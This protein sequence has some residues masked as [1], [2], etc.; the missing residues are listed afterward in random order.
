MMNLNDLVLINCRIREDYWPSIHKDICKHLQLKYEPISKNSPDALASGE[1]ETEERIKL[2]DK[3][4]GEC[5]AKGAKC[6]ELT[7]L[8]LAIQVHL[9]T[10]EVPRDKSQQMLIQFFKRHNQKTDGAVKILINNAINNCLKAG[11]LVN[12][13]YYLG[14]TYK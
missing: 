8:S 3:F 11:D 14:I 10:S 7:G 6:I 12:A 2:M 4:I 9:F 1:A 5:Q 13:G